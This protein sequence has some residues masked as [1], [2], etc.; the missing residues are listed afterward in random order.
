MAIGAIDIGGTKIAVGLVS[1]T[2]QLLIKTSW[3]THPNR[4]PVEGLQQIQN[5][6]D[7]LMK[8]TAIQISGVGIGCT[9]PI[10]PM[11]SELGVNTFLPGWEGFQLCP[12]LQRHYQL[13]VFAEN[14]AD[15]AA[16]GEYYWGCGNGTTRFLYLTISTGIGGG[17]VIDGK[18]YRGAELSH[19]EVGHQVIDP[20]GPMCTCGARGCWEAIASG[21]A[22]AAWYANQIILKG[23][24][25]APLTA[26]E[27]CIQ[28]EAGDPLAFQTIEREGLYLG[29]GIANLVSLFIPDVIAL[30]GGVMQSSH[31]FLEKIRS[32]IQT[33]CNLVPHQK[34]T[35]QAV[36]YQQDAG[37]IGAAAVFL[38]RSKGV[39]K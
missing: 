2:G 24:T 8:K 31:L 23:Y 28:A 14:D 4:G 29:I 25:T 17:L 37:V 38:N 36:K 39:I 9:G 22:M 13:P 16:L 19:P 12:S 1:E 21:P 7:N 26:K 11:T 35:I 27:I 18:L 30:G 32:V 33:N 10:D 20:L 6:L 5:E 34:V 3:S 15:A